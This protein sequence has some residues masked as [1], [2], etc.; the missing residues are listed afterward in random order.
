MYNGLI[1]WRNEMK[2]TTE[3]T[4]DHLPCVGF[5]H[6]GFEFEVCWTSRSLCGK[7]EMI[8]DGDVPLEKG[9]K[10]FPSLLKIINNPLNTESTADGDIDRD[11]DCEEGTVCYTT[12]D[13]H[14]TVRKA[15]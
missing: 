2:R 4:D 12:S 8:E 13:G 1:N 3:W 11:D 7:L 9:L 15:A 5:E 10:R 14:V 6:N